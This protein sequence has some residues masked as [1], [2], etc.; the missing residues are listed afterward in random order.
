MNQKLKRVPL[1]KAIQI[2]FPNATNISLTKGFYYCFGFFD[3]DGQTIYINTGDVRSGRL[4]STKGNC[5]IMIRM[6]KN[7]KDYISGKSLFC[8]NYMLKQKG[9]VVG[10]IPHQSDLYK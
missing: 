6:V 2:V 8:F 4:H 5:G 1:K 3:V 10:S 9:Y 7:R